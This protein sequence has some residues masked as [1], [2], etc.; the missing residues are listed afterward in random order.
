MSDASTLTA[1]VSTT[2]ERAERKENA[3]NIDERVRRAD[4]V[5]GQ[6]NTSL[7]DLADAVE[8]LQFYRQIL[9]EAFDGDVP[10]SV[11]SALQQAED[12][13]D[14][15]RG[16]MVERLID[17]DPERHREEIGDAPDAV[18][19]T[20]RTVKDRLEDRYWSTWEDRISSAEEL[21]AIV[22]D[23]NDE[24]ASVIDNIDSH[25]RAH[26]QDPQRNTSSVVAG[27]ENA[28]DEWKQHQDRQGLD[29]FQRTHGLSNDAVDTIRQL[30]QDSV[31]LA[32][33]DISVLRELKDIPDLEAAVEL[34]I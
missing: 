25:V 18:K 11:H 27:W 28:V 31:S 1:A 22:G 33:I 17:G 7:A 12:A 29:S 3:E 13:A 10:S 30:S 15:D 14:L 19:D 21:Q 16:E 24:F 4:D 9:D 8:Q 34:E 5:L 32:D 20:K 6:I 2:E 26:M 23:R